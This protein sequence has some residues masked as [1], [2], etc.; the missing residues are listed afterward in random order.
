MLKKLPL[1][2]VFKALAVMTCYGEPGTQLDAPMAIHKVSCESL[3][4][5][6]FANVRITS[7]AEVA[8]ADGNPSYCRILATENATEHDIEA[9]LP[10]PWTGRLYQQGGGGFDGRIPELLSPLPPAGSSNPGLI[11]LRNG[12]IVLG[13]NGGYRDPTGAQL[14]GNSAAVERYAHTAI[15]IAKQFGNA[16]AAAYYGAPPKYSYYGG[17]SD[18]GRGAANAAAKYGDDYDGVVAG[19]PGLNVLGLVEGWTRAS[20]LDLPDPAKLA[21]VAAA[22][23]KKCDR[24][25]GAKDGIISNWEACRFDPLTD[26]A[27]AQLTP[28]QASSVQAL[29]SDLKS[30]D[31]TTLY[32]G[33]GFGDMSPWARAYA[34]LGLGYLRNIVLN[35]ASWNPDGFDVDAYYP[36]IY[37]VVRTQYGFDP[38]PEGLVSFL[39]K[40]KKMI[41]WQGSDDTLLSHRDTIR[42]WRSITRMA[43]AQAAK[44]SRLYIA[45]GVN[46]CGGGPGADDFD[47]LG[48][49]MLWVEKGVPPANIVA[50]KRDMQ[51]RK[52]LF[53]RPLC[54]YPQFPRYGGSGD[55]N[56]A[57]NFSCSAR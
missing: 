49:L 42:V 18:G 32:S 9:L 13:S 34:V 47:L 57:T 44:N 22:A 23:V 37:H 36:R 27:S 53:N 2:I 16:L 26:A 43:G 15:K 19:A 24:L 51:T 55:M 35:D 50:S 48:P 14:L 40:G 56:E 31:G 46:H 45:A 3:V 38:E 1:G 7:S 33:L 4:G 39:Q 52:V 6:A 41:I 28:S 29:L 5:R 25:D 20:V 21:A 12:A 10:A 30:K 17:C 11:A 8:A 54:I